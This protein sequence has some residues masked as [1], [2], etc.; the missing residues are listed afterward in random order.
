[1][2]STTSDFISM[3]R[4]LLLF[5]VSRNGNKIR[6]FSDNTMKKKRIK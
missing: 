2:S 1:M 4:D 6:C 5:H 3:Y